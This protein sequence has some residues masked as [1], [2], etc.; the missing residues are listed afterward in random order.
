[1]NDLETIGPK[2]SKTGKENPFRIPDGYFDTLPS[3]VQ[4]LCT[5]QEVDEPSISWG[6]T[7]RTQLALAAGICFFALLAVTGYYYSQQANR[8]NSFERDFIKIV[9]ESG[10]E[11]NEIQLYEAV[12]NGD[13]K[14]TIKKPNNDEL[15]DY[16]FNDY[17]ENGT[18][19]EPTRSIKP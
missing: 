3:R 16:L 13:T 6:V 12:N 7:I 17:I 2:L 19:L 18:L 9:E 14:D 4:E 8:F 10:I 15:M 5:K 11:F 1:M